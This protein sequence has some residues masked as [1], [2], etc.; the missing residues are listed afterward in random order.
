MALGKIKIKDWSKGK[1]K[2]LT[3]WIDEPGSIITGILIGNNIINIVFTALFTLLLVEFTSLWKISHFFIEIISI[4]CSS[5][6]ILMFGEIIPKTFANTYP[7]KIVSL[8][9]KSFM[10]FFRFMKGPIKL[11]NKVS[12]FLAGSMGKKKEKSISRKELDIYLRD[13]TDSGTFG[14]EDSKMMGKVLFLTRTLIK[15]VM[16]P[17]KKIEAINLNWKYS[18]IM[19]NLLKSGYSR[20]PAYRNKIDNYGGFVYI[21][22]VIGILN[23]GRRIDF[24]AIARPAYITFGEENCYNLFKKLRKQRIHIALVKIN[25][26]I[27]GLITIEDL[28]EEIVGEIYDEYDIDSSG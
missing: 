8:F 20:I 24:S 16:T 3:L 9:Y 19:K 11:L 10:R 25:G 1:I 18:K 2:S 14:K 28:I 12:G 26:K 6:L 27:K 21:K 7:E 5:I 17:R 15:D 4:V 13:I 22:D 23:S